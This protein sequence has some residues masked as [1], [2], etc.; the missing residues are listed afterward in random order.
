MDKQLQVF[1]VIKKLLIILQYD[2]KRRL[3]VTLFFRFY[4]ITRYISYSFIFFL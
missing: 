3:E 2:L 4:I 1:V